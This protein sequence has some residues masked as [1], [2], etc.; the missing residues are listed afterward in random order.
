[1]LIIKEDDFLKIKKEIKSAGIDPEALTEK[2]KSIKKVIVV[3]GPT[4]TGKTRLAVHLA[5]LFNTDIISIDSM[6]V[7]RGMDIGTDKFK[8]KDLKIKQYMVDIS[9][10]D[11]PVTVVKFRNI[12]RRVIEDE[13]FKKKR[14]P[15]IAGGSGLYI[16]A[17]I[18]NLEFTAKTGVDDYGDNSVREKIGVDIKKYGLEFIYKKLCDVDPVYAAKIGANDERRIIRALEVFRITGIPFSLFQKRWS[19]RK[20]IYNVSMLGLIMEKKNLNE[21]IETRVEDMFSRGLVK[22][23]KNLLARGYKNCYSLKQALGYK[24][25]IEFLNGKISL[26]DCRKEIIQNTKKLVKKQL[27][28][29]K[30]DMRINWLRTDKY[31]NIL[32]LMIDAIKIINEDCKK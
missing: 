5:E 11:N 26:V 15:L 21:C 17:V 24:E 29:F 12:C 6:Q 14:I 32:N 18:D 1:M 7:Y 20:S 2:L 4:C 10:P 19:D 9:N 3:C 28:W 16:R 31:D 13:F 27:T 25:V 22:E 8:S 30:A 23:V